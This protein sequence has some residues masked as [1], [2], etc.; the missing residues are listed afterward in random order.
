MN[1]K[2]MVSTLD[3]VIFV[4]VLSVVACLVIGVPQIQDHG[5]DAGEICDSIF[6]SKLRAGEVIEG[7]GEA[8][9]P[10][11]ELAAMAVNSG[12]DS[13]IR[14]YIDG[15]MSDVLGDRYV[16]RLEMTYLDSGLVLGTDAGYEPVSSCTREYVIVGD[17]VLTV[18]LTVM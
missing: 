16:Y 10:M 15:V 12:Q 13:F 17:G 2:G 18:T 1:R 11:P 7:G 3:A 4:T 8:V 14:G 6:D 5:P 9:Y